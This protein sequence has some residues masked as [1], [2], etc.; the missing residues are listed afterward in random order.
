MTACVKIKEDYSKEASILKNKNHDIAVLSSIT[1]LM[2]I[3]VIFALSYYGNNNQVYTDVISEMTSV[4]QSNKSIEM[5]LIYAISFVGML[6]YAVYYF[7]QCKK[8]TFITQNIENYKFNIG[9]I[10]IFTI[11]C[12][13]FTCFVIYQSVY[14]LA[15]GAILYMIVC[16]SIEEK[17]VSTGFVAYFMSVYSICALG[18]IFIY[19]GS[20]WS[21]TTSFVAVMALVIALLPLLFENKKKQLLRLCMAEGIFIPFT[22]LL[23]LMD[24]YKLTDGSILQIKQSHPI[25]IT[26]FIIIG[27]FLFEAIWRCIKFWSKHE[28]HIADVINIGTCVA[29]IEFNRFSGMGSI[30]PTDMHHPYEN[31]IGFTQMFELGQQPFENFIP[32]SG[33]YSIIHGA[34]LHFWGNEQFSNYYTVTELFLLF[35]AIIVVL[36]LRKNVEKEILFLISITFFLNDYNRVLFLLPIMLLLSSPTLIKNKNRWLNV[37]FLSSLFHGLY[38][39]L[40]G[41]ASCI[42]FMPFGIYQFVSYIKSGLYKKEIKTIKFWIGW[43]ISIILLIGSVKYLL[44]TLRHMLAMSGQSLLADGLS[45]FGQA[46]PSFMFPYLDGARG[47][48][49]VI[50][51]ILTWLIPAIFI[52]VCFV[53][54]LKGG[55]VSI[56]EKKLY[57]KNIEA[58][59]MFASIII[60]SLISFSFTFVRLDIYSIYARSIG[61][62]L[63]ACIML[64]VY[65]FRYFRNSKYLHYVIGLAIVIP[66]ISNVSGINNL[67]WKLA[68]NYTVPEGYVYVENDSIEKLGTGFVEQGIYNTLKAHETFYAQHDRNQAYFGSPAW[69]GYY[70]YEDI[71]GAASLEISTTVKGLSAAEEA[72]DYVTDNNAIVGANLDTFAN[73]YF[74]NWLLT[75]GEYYFNM[76]TNEFYP[77]NN[78]YTKEEVLEQNKNLQISYDGLNI[79]RQASS[80]GESMETLSKIFTKP[81]VTYDLLENKTGAD[82]IFSEKIDGNEAD[83]L[84]VEFADM[85]NNFDYVFYDTAGQYIQQEEELSWLEKM[86]L[87]KDYNTGM[88]VNISWEDETMQVHNLQCNMSK[89]KLLIPLG[90]GLK[91]LLNSHQS[92]HITVYQDGQVIDM[93]E[94]EAIELLKLREAK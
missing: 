5:S 51:Y 22:L 89:G 60:I 90:S 78:I 31:I 39:P 62:F 4:N 82:V 23:F 85:D 61:V 73:Y 10:N 28:I 88:I 65:A 32:V 11:V 74:Y 76:S 49:Y 79:G 6:I 91:W 40:Y 24:K 83:W 7:T 63:A 2:S 87:K 19:F 17:L 42:G 66:V 80:F 36:A 52:W 34:V 16:F 3:V 25:T 68:A 84:Y 77:N 75:S 53:C 13:A 58:L 64:M 54:M 47:I 56:S 46:L 93:P 94:I 48:Q 69:F 70:Y 8:G 30:L 57:V 14:T 72:I 1:L 44:G 20:E 71:K 33:M 29:I 81:E 18:R 26:I 35:I 59:C 9:K 45:R 55:K 37:W 38:Y 67:D 43:G 21:V 15:I 27:V 50:Y 92:I 41:V 12:I 86:M